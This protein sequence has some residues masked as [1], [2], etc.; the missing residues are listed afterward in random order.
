MNT[1]NPIG[2]TAT[3]LQDLLREHRADPLRQ[4]VLESLGRVVHA[5]QINFPQNLFWDLDALAHSW[6]KQMRTAPHPEAWSANHEQQ[7]I[8]LQNLFGETTSIR[9]QYVHDFLYGYD[10]AK[11]VARDPA[12]R[13]HVGP[14]D[15]EFLT[16]MRTRGQELLELIQ[17]NDKKYHRLHNKKHRNPFPFSRTPAHERLLHRDLAA[18]G[19]LPIAAWAPSTP[20]TWHRPYS[21]IRED[22]AIQLSIPAPSI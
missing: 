11:W 20:P 8:A 10:W 12:A 6:F 17:H 13:K 4:P 18:S 9:F 15:S 21:K 5:I 16:S 2:N 7:L 19:D 22:R 1:L 3:T 14:Y